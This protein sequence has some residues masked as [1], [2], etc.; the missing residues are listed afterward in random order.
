LECYHKHKELYNLISSR[1]YYTRSL[2]A[3][4]F[5]G[6]DTEKILNKLNEINKRIEEL[7]NKSN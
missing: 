3:E 7:K 2:K 4:K 5:D 6:K 1:G